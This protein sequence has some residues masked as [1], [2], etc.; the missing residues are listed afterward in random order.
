VTKLSAKNLTKSYLIGGRSIPVL[1]GLD[2][3]L[4]MNE[5]VAIMGPSGSGKSTL[6]QILGGMVKPDGGELSIGGREISRLRDSELSQL[7]RRELGFVF[8]KF[9]LL[10][11]L[12]ALENTFWPLLLDGRN[13]TESEKRALDLLERVGLVDRAHHSP[14]QL[15]G[16][17]QQRVAIARALIAKPRIVFADEPTGALDSKNSEAILTIL[18]EM[19]RSEGGSLVMVTHDPAAAATCNRLVRLKDGLSC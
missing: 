11:T 2:F 7:R 5:S 3:E 17:E 16:G 6:L 1:R 10:G 15:S 18:H 9:N 4:G 14:T 8:Q 12:T 19:V 13:R